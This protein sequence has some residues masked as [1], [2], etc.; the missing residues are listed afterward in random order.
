M[1]QIKEIQYIDSFSKIG[2]S[3]L[4]IKLKDTVN[5]HDEVWSRLRDYLADVSSQLPSGVLAPKFE[6]INDGRAYTMIIGLTWE[7]DSPPNNA[8]LTRL[9]EEL[10]IQLRSLGNVEKFEFWGISSEEILVEIRPADLAALRITPQILSQQIQLSDAKV[11]SGSL[12]SSQYNVN[13]EVQTELESLERIRQIPIRVNENSSQIVLLGDVARVKKTIQD[14]PREF[15]IINGKLGVVLAVLIEPNTRIDQW[16]RKAHKILEDFNNS[17]SSGISLQ[18]ILDQNSYISDRL[19]NLF[20]NILL[21]SLLVIASTAFLMGWKSAL[22]ISS[23]LPLS[24]LMVFSGMRMLEIPLHQMS[25]TGLIIALGMLIDNAIVVVDEID[26]LLKKGLPTHKAISQAVSYIATPLLAS[27][28]TTLLAF[29][30]I[31]LM[32]GPIGEYVKT[33]ALSVILALSSSLFLSLTI[34][35]AMRGWINSK[36]EKYRKYNVSSSWWKRGISISWLTKIYRNTLNYILL[37]PILGIIVA[38]ILPVTGLFLF[39]KIPE[40]FFAPAERDQF[41]IKLELPLSTSIEQTKSVTERVSDLIFQYPEV[42]ELHWFIGTY[43]PAFYYTVERTAI[44]G[45]IPH[46]ATAMVQISTGKSSIKLIQDLQKQI[47]QAFPEAQ[48]LVEQLKQAIP[49]PPIELRLYGP[50]LEILEQLGKQIRALLVHVPNVIHTKSSLGKNLPQLAFSSDEEQ[51]RLIGLDH[52]QISQQLN[53]LLEGNIGGSLLEETEE[54]PVRVRIANNERSQLGQIAT[55]DLIPN[56]SLQKSSVPLSNLGELSLVPEH[57]IITHRNGRRCNIIHGFI[58][59]G[60][61]PSTVLDD[62]TERLK[63]KNFQLP[64]GYS[65]EWGGDAVERKKAVDNL[66]VYMIIL[67][68]LMISILVLS[69][70][71]FRCALIIC[72]VAIASIGLALISLWLFNYPF[73]FLAILGTVGLIGI[74]INDSIVVLAAIRADPLAKKGN[75][76]AIVKVVICSTRHVLTTTI[77]TI[78]GFLPILIEGGQIWPPLV[79]CIAGGISGTTILALFFVPCMYLV[80]NNLKNFSSLKFASK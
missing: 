30:P 20:R 44:K 70:Y 32:R 41:Q 10:E 11:S 73:G 56:N 22:V 37:R 80:L 43:A 27:T 2:T 19:N 55:L 53:A 21:G 14:P 7:Q 26:N 76:K 57:S 46:Y 74:A 18:L 38:L 50:S 5:D 16:T 49:I 60:V 61:L 65:M 69:F 52:T 51:A 64:P 48:I 36:E 3:Q 1:Q 25:L 29:I 13:I 15:A 71:S 17:L 59:A 68:V 62:F 4:L 47:N 67:L 78:T 8:I 42:I 31:A 28:L 72:L 9:A 34:I 58:K 75:L 33:I 66:S 39:E 79:I 54:L 6:D 24:I 77:T 23:S 45:E 40:Q 12:R 35:P 63:A